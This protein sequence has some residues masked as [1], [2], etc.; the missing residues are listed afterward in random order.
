M[1]ESRFVAGR[2]SPE[3][4]PEFARRLAQRAVRTCGVASALGVGLSLLAC[5]HPQRFEYAKVQS[6]SMREEMEYSVYVPKD[7]RPNEH[8]PLVLFLHGAG[9][10][11][12]ALDAAEVGGALDRGGK[13]RA[14][15]VAPQGDRGFWENWASGERNYRDWVLRE[16]MPSLQ[17]RYHT[18]PCPEG[19]HVVG[20]SMG[21]YGAFMSVLRNPGLFASAASLSGPIYTAETVKGFYES[22]FWGFIVP[23][24]RIW[25]PY[26][27]AAIATR[28]LY[29]QWTKPED[30]HGTRVLI[31]W[32]SQDDEDIRKSG[33]LF[34]AHLT[35]ARI[36]HRTIRFDGGHDWVSWTPVLL[37][38]LA[39]QV[40]GT[41]PTA[42]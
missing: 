25:G 29:R 39:W 28:D 5:S 8:L 37:D 2:R 41:A 38:T 6:P 11:P 40:N 42:P 30:L 19:C 18:A 14:I 27:P 32:G 3:L 1:K 20:V 24:E 35:R 31:A 34:D 16:L 26:D 4:C 15:L 23:T 36:P 33:E 9:D 22:W 7:L 21:A 12:D 13:V 10:G 17:A